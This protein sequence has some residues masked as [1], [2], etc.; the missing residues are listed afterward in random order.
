MSLMKLQEVPA[1]I[2][3]ACATQAAALRAHGWM[4]QPEDQLPLVLAAS[5][6]Q[7]PVKDLRRCKTSSSHSVGPHGSDNEVGISLV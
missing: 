5:L 4:L 3:N 1:A 2:S 6:P 7:P